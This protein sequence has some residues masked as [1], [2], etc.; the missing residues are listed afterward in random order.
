MGQFSVGGNKPGPQDGFV[1]VEVAV[2]SDVGELNHLA[3]DES[4]AASMK[5]MLEALS[6][7][8]SGA[9]CPRRLAAQPGRHA[10]PDD[11]VGRVGSE[12]GRIVRERNLLA[13]RLRSAYVFYF[14]ERT[15][16]S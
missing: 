15:L 3:R 4:L 5:W 2:T 8:K 10:P 14:D 6:L 7:G 1:A 9:Q 12:T 13:L 11:C 16:P